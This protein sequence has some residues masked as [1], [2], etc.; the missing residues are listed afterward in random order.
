MQLEG[1]ALYVVNN[2]V[3]VRIC[4]LF[5]LGRRLTYLTAAAAFSYFITLVQ[6]DL[7]LT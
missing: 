1:F 5:V 4:G 6:F 7:N 2:R 3:E